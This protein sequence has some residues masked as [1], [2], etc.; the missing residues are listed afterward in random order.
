M[1]ESLLSAKKAEKK[2]WEMFFVGLVYVSVAVLF[3]LWIFQGYGGF[4]L[5][6]LTML[7]STI[8]IY[9]II[10]LEELKDKKIANE[11]L[12]LKEHS[13]ALSFFM[14]LF[15]GFV[16]AFSLW[17]V[18]LP[19][20]TASV[21]FKEQITTINKINTPPEVASVIDLY[22]TVGKIFWNNFR[23][24]GLSLIFSLFYGM[25]AIFILTWNA[26]VIGAAIGNF[27]RNSLSTYANTLGFNSMSAYLHV[28][29][30]GLLRYL[31]HGVIE[32]SAYFLAG[33][34]GGI[35][36][37]AVVRHDFMS[38]KFKHIISDATDL[39]II[40]IAILFLAA[41]VEVFI[42]PALF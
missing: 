11:W 9:N 25:G 31:T 17:Y 19:G 23:V 3:C 26:S 37:V 42:T 27:I 39:V 33:L 34:A 6:S 5:V 13:K 12:L 4:V 30:I 10:K 2:P 14:F 21:L 38:K 36:S 20:D 41:L 40:S 35:I 15:L 32:I 24:L 1:L 7:A 22:A 16:V 28:L 18:F 8:L 29:S